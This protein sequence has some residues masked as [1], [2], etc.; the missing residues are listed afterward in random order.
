MTKALLI[1]LLSTLT[2]GVIA[3]DWGKAPVGKA[4]IEECIDLGGEITVGYMSDYYYRGFHVADSS[5]YADVNYTFDKLAVPVTIGAL[6]INS[7]DSSF[8]GLGFDTLRLYADADLGT[9]AGFDFNLKYTYHSFPEG[10]NPLP[11]GGFPVGDGVG[12]VSLG[13]SRDLGFAT[14]VGSANY[15]L[16]EGSPLIGSPDLGFYG[17]VGLEKSIGLTDNISLVLAGGVGYVDMF[18]GSVTAIRGWNHYYLTAS[19]P[20]QLNCRTTL[21]PY[22]GFNNQS[23][24]TSIFNPVNLAPSIPDGDDLHGGVSISVTF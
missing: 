3:G 19:L 17:N 4:P 11:V 15:Y 7:F 20:I 8:F 24:F 22:I 21:T 14:L 9:F 10:F 23:S 6:Y 2:L 18:G 1:T 5:L 16:E 13:F 12:E